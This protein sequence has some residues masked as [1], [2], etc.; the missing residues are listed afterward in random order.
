MRTN[1]LTPT[2]LR[3]LAELRPSQGKVL[4]LF[5]DLDPVRFADAAARSSSFGSLRHEAERAVERAVDLDD[6][7]RRAL[8]EDL[9]R[10]GA[11]LDPDAIPA[12]GAGSLAIFACQPADLFEVI[13]LPEP[14]EQ[15]VHLGS[16]P[17][18]APLAAIGPDERWAVLLVDKRVARIF[19]GPPT[20]AA[21]VHTIDDET[22]GRH[23]TGGWSQAR[24]QRSID[25]EVSD[26]LRHVA[27][28]LFRMHER[29]PFDH[30]LLAGPVEATSEMEHRLHTDLGRI[31]CGRFEID[32]QS[33]TPEQVRTAAM[34]FVERQ[35]DETESGLLGELADGRGTGRGVAGLAPVVE[36]LVQARVRTLLLTPRHDRLRDVRC[37]PS[38]DWLG[39]DG[40]TAC[41]VDGTE[42][43]SVEAAEL[44]TTRALTQ[45]A[46]VV[47]FREP[48]PLEPHEG[49]AAILRF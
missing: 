26:H 44:V 42:L 13:R 9:E 10:I 39:A 21:E 18:V 35:R 27:E 2:R 36:A 31:L 20:A 3:E 43:R 40:A 30:L 49:I 34:A 47:V 6:D 5:V 8:H 46:D 16:E 14:V 29:E 33:S 11:L 1:E 4:S 28:D 23:S 15:Q 38:C 22:H 19:A 7:D 41:P 17:F 32:V 48:E 37:C 12:N 45:D 24:Y 25:E